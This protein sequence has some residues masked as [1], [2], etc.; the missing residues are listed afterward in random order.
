MHHAS[1]VPL[2]TLQQAIRTQILTEQKELKNN[3]SVSN[4]E[5]DELLTNLGVAL[6]LSDAS[7]EAIPDTMQDLCS[8]LLSLR[9]PSVFSSSSSL[10]SSSLSSS[11]LSFTASLSLLDEL[12]EV[13]SLVLK[14]ALEDA[15]KQSS[16]PWHHSRFMVVGEGGAGKSSF[17]RSLTGKSFTA[18]HLSTVGIAVEDCSTQMLFERDEAE[19]MRDAGVGV[20]EYTNWKVGGSSSGSGGDND[21]ESELDRTLWQQAAVFAN[22]PKAPPKRPSVLPPKNVEVMSSMF[23]SM[24]GSSSNSSK[25]SALSTPVSSPSPP[26]T[27]KLSTSLPQTPTQPTIPPPPSLASKR[28]VDSKIMVGGGGEGG[29]VGG[30]KEVK[31]EVKVVVVEKEKEDEERMDKVSSMG[32]LILGDDNDN[33]AKH[34]LELLKQPL[35]RDAGRSLTFSVWDFGKKK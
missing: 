35:S 9:T 7:K 12:R 15:L 16:R 22:K 4:F 32:Q 26:P 6:G 2:A 34:N 28:V 14:R 25:S 31:A 5:I 11:S 27:P 19:V 30:S 17:V 13:R 18:E 21:Y 10:S 23:K 3:K 1:P 33:E 24:F 20:Q 8:S 29:G